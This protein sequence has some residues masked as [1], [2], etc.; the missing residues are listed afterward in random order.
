MNKKQILIAF[1]GVVFPLILNRISLAM[2]ANDLELI[3]IESKSVENR[4]QIESGRIVLSV[5]HTKNAS[6]PMYERISRE[7]SLVFDR[8][9]YRMDCRWTRPG[10]TTMYYKILTPHEVVMS[11]RPDSPITVNDR[12]GRS[13]SDVGIPDPRVLGMVCAG[14]SSLSQYGLEDL[15]LRPDR[16]LVSLKEVEL[17]GEL[18]WQCDYTC[19]TKIPLQCTTWIAPQK[20]Y[21]LVKHESV[22][23][24]RDYRLVSQLRV[25]SHFYPDGSVW[26]PKKVVYRSL[27]NDVLEREEIMVIESASFGEIIPDSEFAATGLNL[28]DGTEFMVR[29]K[30]L[31]LQN[32]KLA[33]N[34]RFSPFGTETG[35][36][37]LRFPFLI[38][39]LILAV[40]ASIAFVR[41]RMGAR[42]TR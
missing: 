34:S 12:G 6:Q 27:M 13:L 10:G 30:H 7:Y 25:T 3:K 35:V 33:T 37:R 40:I 36:S 21:T 23:T 19:D 26:F 18:V 28:P 17:D 22:E 42:D 32:G 41:Y 38:A 2:E 8:K 11:S 29:S 4:R 14:F 9:R 5:R 24:G 15:L 39:S 16:K 20:G 1:T 31:T